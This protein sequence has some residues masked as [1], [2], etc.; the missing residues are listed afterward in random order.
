MVNLQIPSGWKHVLEDPE[1]LQI[2]FDY[3]GITKPPLSKEVSSCYAYSYFIDCIFK[4]VF[5]IL[6][7]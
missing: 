2:F 5:C 4:M 7:Q 1:T 6:T 3:Y